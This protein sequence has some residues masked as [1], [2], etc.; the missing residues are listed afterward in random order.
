M[1]RGTRN[2]SVLPSSRD[3]TKCMNRVSAF[4]WWKKARTLAGLEPK[5]GRSWHSQRRKFVMDLMAQV[6]CELGGWRSPKT[7]L[8]CYQQTN[9]GQLRKAL[10]NRPRVRA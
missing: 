8:R 4:L 7:V 6:L 9:P 1:S 2:I 3:A 5:P 10:E